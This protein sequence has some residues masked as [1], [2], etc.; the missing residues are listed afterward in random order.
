MTKPPIFIEIN[1]QICDHASH[2]K[3]K[4]WW[5]VAARAGKCPGG[6]VG[7]RADGVAWCGKCSSRRRFGSF[8]FP[9]L[10]R[11]HGVAGISGNGLQHHQLGRFP[12]AANHAVQKGAGGGFGQNHPRRLEFRRRGQQCDS[13]SLAARRGKTLP[14][15]QS[16]PGFDG[17]SRRV[18]FPRAR[19][20]FI[21]QTF[22]N[23][24]LLFNTAAGN[25]PV[26]ADINFYDYGSEPELHAC[27]PLVLAGQGDVAGTGLAGGH[28]P[29]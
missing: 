25:C 19:R 2:G 3:A 22:T 12:D 7:L 21:Y 9:D 6:L 24:H 8:Q 29:E 17:R 27:G 14:R 15:P 1:F 18:F 20:R 4:D 10:K 23:I 11:G 28:H 5:R 13:L 16:E 26:L